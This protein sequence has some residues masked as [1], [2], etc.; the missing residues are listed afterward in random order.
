VLQGDAPMHVVNGDG[1]ADHPLSDPNDGV[2]TVDTGPDWSPDGSHVLFARTPR[3]DGA[4]SSIVVDPAG[5]APRRFSE[6][7]PSHQDRSN[8]TPDSR[9]VVLI[10]IGFSEARLTRVDGSGELV[11]TDGVLSAT[12]LSPDGRALA[13]ASQGGEVSATVL[14]DGK[15]SVV[16]S[17]SDNF[18]EWSPDGSTLVTRTVQSDGSQNYTAYRIDGRRNWKFHD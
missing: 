4:A 9:A 15:R 10:R 18:L 2:D 6:R 5:T 7:I 1:T 13:S 8:W 3:G 16:A 14:A 11:L 17:N 12:S